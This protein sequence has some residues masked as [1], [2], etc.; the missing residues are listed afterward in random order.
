MRT[1]I[2]SALSGDMDPRQGGFAFPRPQSQQTL[3]DPSF[4]HIPPSQYATQPNTPRADTLHKNDPFLRR[5]IDLDDPKSTPSFA[6]GPGQYGLP[7][8]SHYPTNHTVAIQDSIS[9]DNRSRHSSQ[10]SNTTFSAG[11]MDRFGSHSSQGAGTSSDTIFHLDYIYPYIAVTY[12]A[13]WSAYCTVCGHHICL[14]LP[15]FPSAP[16]LRYPSTIFLL[17]RM[18][19][20][21]APR[22]GVATCCSL[23]GHKLSQALSMTG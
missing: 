20:V 4:P 10:S 11:R 5:R 2:S 21:Q 17:V 13:A 3:R 14:G 19:M 9:N 16:K 18:M 15:I 7:T 8:T 1:L 6:Q 12:L 23:L 22:S